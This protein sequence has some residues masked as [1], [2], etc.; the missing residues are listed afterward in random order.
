MFKTLREPVAGL[1]KKLLKRDF[2]GNTGQALKNSVF[3][4]STTTIS[5][6]G[7]I[8]FTIILARLLLPELFGLY[9]LALSTIM[10]FASL[11][12][13]GIGQTMVKFISSSK[14]EKK[15]KAYF[16]YLIRIKIVLTL[17]SATALILLAGFFS[18][19]FY[20]KPEIYLALMAGSLY[21][22]FMGFAGIFDGL[23]Q[24]SNNFKK[25]FYRELIVQ[26]SRIILV[27]LAILFAITH[28]ADNFSL[29]L[30]LIFIMLS[31]SYI[32][33]FLFIFFSARRELGFLKTKRTKL[34]KK[35]KANLN[36][37]I[38]ALSAM[39][40]ASALFGHIDM[41]M[42]G[43][44]V[45]SE[46]IG[47]YRA[48]FSLITSA[49]PFIT[50]SGA[51]FPIFSRLKGKRL[52]IG[53]RKSVIL[54]LFLAI[55]ASVLTFFISPFVVRIIYGSEYTPASNILR[56]FSILIILLPLIAIH[57]SYLVSQNKPRK[58]ASSL[59]YSMI[60]NAV[61]N[62]VLIILLLPQGFMVAV[63]GAT[64]ATIISK[65]VYLGLLLYHN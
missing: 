15:S 61:L 13:L 48:A 65:F 6:I 35:E 43:R 17:I 60:V 8:V 1:T 4:F 20:S 21:L 55:P 10:I 28:F 40:V 63:Y 46:F 25:G 39:T 37:F 54:T 45:S 19:T 16:S 11:S 9:S 59:C 50:F 58:V 2:S 26:T 36:K 12:S 14:S 32:L 7:S 64:I 24:A 29:L 62:F 56:I 38:I 5:K 30:F 31:V 47:F 44:Y 33:A 53:L 18:R 52:K 41:V 57:S 51:L 42:L 23:F 22:I 49:A 34:A 27:P 3:S